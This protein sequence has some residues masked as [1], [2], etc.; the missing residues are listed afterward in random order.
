VVF[1]LSPPFPTATITTLYSFTGEADG[2]NPVA[3]L[4]RNDFTGTLY[5]T[6][7]FGGDFNVGVVF[8]LNPTTGVYTPLYSFKGGVN[9][10]YPVAGLVRDASGTLYGTTEF[11]GPNGKGN[12]FLLRAN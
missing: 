4:V 3:G 6:T 7:E 1:K 8:Q 5:G 12:V 10:A 9:G 11:G 2:G